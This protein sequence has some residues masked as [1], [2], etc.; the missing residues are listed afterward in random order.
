MK[1]N[2]LS[3]L[4]ALIIT[5][6]MSGCQKWKGE[7]H[8]I[9]S[10][11]APAAS[12]VSDAAPLS[13]GGG[14]TVVSVKGTMLTGKTYSV[15]AG[16]DLV[17]NAADTLL[18]QPGVTLN[19]GAGSSIIALGTFVSNGSKDQPNFITY[20][21]LTQSDVP[22]AL[23][24]TADPA[25]SGK[26]KGIIGGPTCNLLV[27]RWTH[28]QYA[29]YTEGSATS[30]IASSSSGNQFSILFAN[31][32]GSFV[33][34]DSWL[35]GGVDDGIRISAGKIALF[36]NTFEKEGLNGGD[37]I[38]VKGG[39]TGTM[40]Y[41]F[42]IG[43]ATNGQKAS[44]KGQATGAPQTNLVMYNNTFV[45]GGYRQTQ[46]G[47]GGSIDYEEGAAGMYYNNVA[48]NC[49][50]GYRMLGNPTADIAHLSYGNNFQYGDSLFVA[51]QFYPTG[52]ITQPQATD[53]PSITT[54]AKYLPATYKPGDVYDGSDVV[55]KNPPMFINFPLPATGHALAQYTA[56][57]SY[58]FHLQAGSPLVG[59]SNTSIKPLITVPLNA[60]YGLAEATP[61]GADLGCYQ[62][63]G[64]GNQH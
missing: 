7:E 36:R 34:E 8:S 20:P 4:A 64:T 50:F 6:V 47:R 53:V 31:Y 63:T 60:V 46:S 48:V 32:K 59:K 35:Y 41:N 25:N 43:T 62:L 37:C 1:T 40:A 49:K 42:F 12:P 55:Q 61:A 13:C 10:Y 9:Y 3:L 18:M 29:G 16:C 56:V 52:Y 22:G 14:S 17:I 19:M 5:A 2:I 58:N 28:L 39:T 30:T 33:M 11:T 24:A 44:N 45:S 38:N 26:W 23:P 15:A 51:N 21:G 57:G 54:S 27:L